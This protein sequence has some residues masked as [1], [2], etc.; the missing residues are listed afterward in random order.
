MRKKLLDAYDA[1]EA[2]IRA[3]NKIIGEANDKLN[4]LAQR[5]T[6]S[7]D[8]NGSTLVLAKASFNLS[9]W[10]NQ[11]NLYFVDSKI[12]QKY[13]KVAFEE[14]EQKE[15]ARL[16]TKGQIDAESLCDAVPAETGLCQHVQFSCDT[17]W[18]ADILETREW[19]LLVEGEDISLRTDDLSTRLCPVGAV[20]QFCQA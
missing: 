12:A 16:Y 10:G 9:V 19:T 14:P 20:T 5:L 4:G 8:C 11:M 13:K 2:Q 18:L 17:A 7:L 6:L 1:L 3:S 15:F